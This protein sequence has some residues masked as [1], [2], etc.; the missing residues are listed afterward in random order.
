MLITERMRGNYPSKKCQ[1]SV[2]KLLFRFDNRSTIYLFIYL[3]TYLFIYLLHTVYNFIRVQFETL[4]V[5]YTK[6]TEHLHSAM[7]C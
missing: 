5:K 1:I 3:F 4:Q 7:D 6:I 2:P